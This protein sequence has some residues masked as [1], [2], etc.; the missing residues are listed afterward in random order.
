MPP[1]ML[2]GTSC[3][4]ADNPEARERLARRLKTPVVRLFVKAVEAL[5]LPGIQIHYLLRKLALA[6]CRT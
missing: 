4:A 3:F 2:E 5:V 6:V 1:G